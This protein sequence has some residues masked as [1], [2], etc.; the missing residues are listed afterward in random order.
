MLW[1]KPSGV[2]LA[3]LQPDDLVPLDLARVLSR[4]DGDPSLLPAD[5]DPV[6][7]VATAARLAPA[8]GRRPSVELLFHAL[9]PE[10]FVIH[11]HPIAANAITC[12]V[13]GPELAAALFGER[14]SWVPYADPGLP[15]ARA[16]RSARA[17]YESRTG[18]AAPAI[19]LLANHGLI[20]AGDTVATIDAATAWLL[21]AIDAASPAHPPIE[22]AARPA[23][24]AATVHALSST[25]GH[26]VV[27]DDDP[28]AVDWA[29]TPAGRAFMAGGPLI[30]D[31]IVYAGSWPMV[32]DLD[33]VGGERLVP[34]VE[35]A[36]HR[37]AKRRGTAPIVTVAPGVGLFASGETMRS[38]ATARDVYLDMLRVGF[39]AAQ[40]GGVC[41]LGNDQRRFIEDWEAE[42][43]RR[44][45]GAQRQ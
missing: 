28:L 23:P 5:R 36:L 27:Y 33:G 40:F 10:R 24:D 29:G 16:V 4:L 2:P 26:A 8:H 30:P 18:L 13:A 42:D 6:M 21:E 38:A 20:V 35:A 22:K 32:L 41:H 9:M 7:D 3:T 12:C 11:T 14:A 45:V 37:F 19:T 1:I 25:L 15:L 34:L 44:R 39:G 17:A 43:Y 31:Q